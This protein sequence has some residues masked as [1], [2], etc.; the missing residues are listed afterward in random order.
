MPPGSRYFTGR[1]LSKQK[2]VRYVVWDGVKGYKNRAPL[3]GSLP[4]FTQTTLDRP[5]SKFRS[6]KSSGSIA[7]A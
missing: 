3:A 7:A 4:I 1:I 5:A 2:H 6:S